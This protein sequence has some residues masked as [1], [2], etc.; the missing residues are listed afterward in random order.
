MSSTT[1]DVSVIEQHE[2]SLKTLC[3]I[4][5]CSILRYDKVTYEVKQYSAD[6]DSTFMVSTVN[7]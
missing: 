4:C 3:R 1:S 5:G 6:T 7:D 2:A